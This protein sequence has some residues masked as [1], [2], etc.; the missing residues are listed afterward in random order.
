VTPKKEH[1]R[2]LARIDTIKIAGKDAGKKNK[3][4]GGIKHGTYY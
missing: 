2:I 1:C 3:I 4:H